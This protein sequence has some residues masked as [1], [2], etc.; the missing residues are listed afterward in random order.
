MAT[1]PGADAPAA[2]PPAVEVR[3]LAVRFGGVQALDDVS[4]T[5]GPGE[6]LGLAGQNGAGKSTFVNILAGVVVP[7]RGE[8]FLHGS[9]APVGHPRAMSDAGVA[10]VSQEQAL[11]PTMTVWENVFL[12][13]EVLSSPLGLTDRR[14]MREATAL[15]LEELG[16]EGI[17]PGQSV[18]DLPFASRQLVEI[19]RAVHRARGR[20]RPIV[21]L[22]EPTSGLSPRE[23]EVLFSVVERAAGR[24]TFVFVSHVLADMLRLCQRVVVLTNGRLVADRPAG[25][26]TEG[27]LHELMVGRRR[28]ED[29]Y[30]VARQRAAAVDQAQADAHA[31]TDPATLG[32]DAPIAP[33]DVVLELHRASKAGA[34]SD[35]SFAVAAGEVVGLAGIVGSGVSEVAACL[36]GAS[37][38]SGGELR[39]AGRHQHRWTVRDA[40]AHQVRYVPPERRRDALIGPGTVADNIAVAFLDGL[41]GPRTRLLN[42]ARTSALVHRLIDRVQ[43]RPPDPRRLIGELSGGNQQKAVF[44]RLIGAPCTVAVLDNPT[45]GVDV[46]TREEIYTLIRDLA[47]AGAGVVVTSESLAELIGLSDRLLVLRAG[48]IV[49]ELACPPQAKPSEV[50]VL[51]VL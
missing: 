6:V 23:V 11:V 14:G 33:S 29:F 41:V 19:T 47:D 25:E 12:G 39:V 27:I 32:S 28:R 36:A 16:I 24:T 40:L 42:Q 30:A 2:A 4:L 18:A 3:H 34:F 15:L 48:R 37:A 50:D 44:A 21:V 38:L 31:A 8:V 26:V 22:D 49:A 17:A 13:D 43:L 46:A 35:V 7:E 9:P 10:V 5:V 1:T 51:A 20:R 45:R